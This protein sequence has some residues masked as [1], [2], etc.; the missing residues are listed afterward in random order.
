MTAAKSITWRPGGTRIV[1]YAVGVIMIVL[2][3]AIAWALPDDIVFHFSERV[4]LGLILGATLLGL[5]G[6]GRSNVMADETGVHVLN[7][8]RQHDV[9][10][11]DIQGFSMNTGAPWPTL[12]TTSDDRIMLFAI[13]GSEGGFARAAVQELDRRLVASR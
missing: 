13:Q 12:V 3:V 7:G 6:I 4:T 11:A 1:A 8:F 5:H 2:T 10:W 9:A